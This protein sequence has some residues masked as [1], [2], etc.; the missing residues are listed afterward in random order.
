MES[1]NGES[2][3]MP[4]REILLKNNPHMPIDAENSVLF[5]QV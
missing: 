1:K 5:K 3:R 2:N 4:L